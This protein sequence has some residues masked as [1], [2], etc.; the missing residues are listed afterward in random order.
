MSRR[1]H[2]GVLI[3]KLGALGDVIVS[4]PFIEAIVRHHLEEEIFLLTAPAFAPLFAGHPRL[5]VVAF[6]RKGVRAMSASLAWI[7][8]HRFHSI[9]D[10]QNSD[11]SALMVALSGAARRVGRSPGGIYNVRPRED[12]RS[13]H[14]FVRLA[15]LLAS[16]GIPQVDPRPRLWL[17]AAAEAAGRQWL[18][19]RGLGGRPLALLHAGSSANWVSK[20]WPEENFAALGRRLDAAGIDVVWVGG[21]PERALNARLASVVGTDASDALSVIELAALSRLAAFAVTGDSGPMHVMSTAGIPVFSLFGPTDWRRHHALGQEARVLVHK[22]D[23]SPCY[24]GTCPARRGH[25]CLNDIS[26]DEV[27]DRIR[28]DPD[29]CSIFDTDPD[30][31]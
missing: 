31:H 30:R 7:R 24:L 3:I 4:T 29:C 25:L 17:D 1:G 21:G 15:A 5:R 19:A 20:R 22:V 23:C 16:A 26:V 27:F 10:L 9:Y 13:A 18:A 28:K 2:R 11:R 14:I 8:R 12:D 6:P